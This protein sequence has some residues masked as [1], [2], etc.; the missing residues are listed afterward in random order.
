VAVVAWSAEPNDVP[1]LL[2][3]G[4]TALCGNDVPALLA[5]AKDCPTLRQSA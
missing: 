5:A 3:R 1:G 4:D 2:D